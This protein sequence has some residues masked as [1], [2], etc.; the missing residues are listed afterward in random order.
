MEETRSRRVQND[1]PTN[2]VSTGPQFRSTVGQYSS[3]E[4]FISLRDKWRLSFIYFFY[5]FRVLQLKMQPKQKKYLSLCDRIR[6][7]TDSQ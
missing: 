1:T 2:P 5:I 7:M 6:Q 3:K 4:K